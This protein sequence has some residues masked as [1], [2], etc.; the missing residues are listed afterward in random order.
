MT[1]KRPFNFGAG[2]AAL[3]LSVLQEVKSELLN[4]K[5]LGVSVMEVGHRTTEVQELMSELE[6]GFRTLLHIPSGYDVLFLNG[7]AR[8]QFALIPLNLLSDQMTGAYILSG[9]WSTLAFQE[10]NR[11]KNASCIGDSANKQYNSLPHITGHLSSKVSYV[12]Y[13][14][15]E[16]I[17]GVR[18][19]K[20]LPYS[21]P[22]I[23]DMTSCLLTEPIDISNYGLIFAGSQKNISIPGLTVVI[24]RHNLL[25]SIEQK[26]IPTIFDYRTHAQYHS[27]YATPPVFNCY[28]ANKVLTWLKNQGGIQA[29]Y[30]QNCEKAKLLYEYIDEDPFYNCPVSQDAR[31]LVN[32]RFY[33]KNSKLDALF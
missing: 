17:E 20:T 24:I 21:V 22:L 29:I 31:S 11:F 8:H 18:W 10:C 5:N 7:A 13:T 32:V 2:P 9:T 1:K 23:A 25:E 14:P 30:Q 16:T 27:L 28:I 33:L 26:N 3:P 19:S 6:E 15:N 12:Y 4:W